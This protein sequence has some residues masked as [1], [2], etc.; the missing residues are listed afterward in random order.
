ME[1]VCP[2]NAPVTETG[3][4]RSSFPNC[5]TETLVVLLYIYHQW[6]QKRGISQS[7]EPHP[8][9][10]ACYCPPA[11]MKTTKPLKKEPH[12]WAAQIKPPRHDAS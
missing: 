8:K 11:T 2:W 12:S 10:S 6:A 7:G 1:G 9:V 3:K 5:R 4:P